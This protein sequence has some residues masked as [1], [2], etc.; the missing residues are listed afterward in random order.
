MKVL[1]LNAP[2][3][4]EN[5]PSKWGVRGGSRWPHFQKRSSTGQLPRYI[6]FP[7]FMATAAAVIR[8]AGYETMIIDAVAEDINLLETYRRVN[9]FQPDLIFAESS[10]PSLN[11]DLKVFRELRKQHPKAVLVSGGS[12]GVSMVPDFMKKHGLPDYWLGG[13]FDISLLTLIQTLET[14]GDLNKVP[15][16]ICEGIN[17]PDRKSVV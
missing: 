4:D 7:F 5:D 3:Y 6:P 14:Q 2:W 12:Q 15:G 16:L 17:N 8:N 10:T 9:A 1:L 13:E 11:W